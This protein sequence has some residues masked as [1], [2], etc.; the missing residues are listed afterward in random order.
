MGKA[1]AANA[2]LAVVT[3]DNPRMEDPRSI[4]TQVAR[5][6]RFQWQHEVVVDRQE[7]IHWALSEARPDDCVLVAGKGHEDYQIVGSDRLPFD[8]RLVVRSVLLGDLQHRRS[9]H[10]A[11]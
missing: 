7:A 1:V 10:Q 2:D 6:F 11:A 8:D 5:G 9:A 3:S 4:I